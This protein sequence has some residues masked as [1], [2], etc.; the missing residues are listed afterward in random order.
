[1]LS[2]GDSISGVLKAY[3]LFESVQLHQAV[4]IWEEI[5]GPS[6][7][8]HIRAVE[9][10]GRTLLVKTDNPAW[11]TEIAFQKD[12]LLRII[13]EKIGPDTIRDIRFR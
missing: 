6:V 10:K 1:M 2:L 4:V 7:A 13:N 8:K 5:V 12:E 11:R 3:G 9:V